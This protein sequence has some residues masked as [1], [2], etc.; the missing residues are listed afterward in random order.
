MATP[1]N[2]GTWLVIGLVVSAVLALA[3]I[4]WMQQNAY[5]QT[6]LQ[7]SSPQ[8]LALTAELGRV[9]GPS[10]NLLPPTDLTQDRAPEH[11][12]YL[13]YVSGPA[14][15]NLLTAE[16][17]NVAAL[18]VAGFI[19]GKPRVFL[20]LSPGP[21]GQ[22]LSNGKPLVP[23]TTLH[24]GYN[25]RLAQTAGAAPTWV[26]VLLDSMQ[27]PMSDELVLAWDAACNCY[28]PTQ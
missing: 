27:Q 24:A 10:Y 2:K 23:Q 20:A 5:R 15:T 25:I 7:G 1:R 8:E 13:P 17:T 28:K 16:G 21:G 14:T 4:G 19:R 6:R 26:V 3:A 22:I 9:L 11:I 18:A 12:G